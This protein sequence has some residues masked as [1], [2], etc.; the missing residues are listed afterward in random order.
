MDQ[1]AKIQHKFKLYYKILFKIN[2]YETYL[3][4][5]YRFI[6]LFLFM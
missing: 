3:I 2:K 6:H 4:Y 5:H 1:G